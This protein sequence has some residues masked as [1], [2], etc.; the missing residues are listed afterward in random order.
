MR[1]LL[2]VLG[3]L[4]VLVLV[5]LIVLI[6]LV[7]L[8]ILIILIVSVLVILIVLHID[9]L[10]F[11]VSKIFYHTH[12][13]R[14]MSMIY[15]RN[16]RHF[17]RTH[18]FFTEKSSVIHGAFLYDYSNIYFDSTSSPIASVTKKSVTKKTNEHKV[19]T[20]PAN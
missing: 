7:I 20:K 14:I 16:Q 10:R 19:L 15:D 13:R 5:V 2:S 18:I 1:K 17:L 6:V 3:I 12:C 4:I 11:S 9:V 8:I